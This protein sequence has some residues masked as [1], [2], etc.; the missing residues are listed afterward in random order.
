MSA[1]FELLSGR[2]IIDVAFLPLRCMHEV[3][4]VVVASCN[5]D[6][7]DVCLFDESMVEQGW[8][9]YF[10]LCTSR[11]LLPPHQNSRPIGNK[12][13]LTYRALRPPQK[14]EYWPLVGRIASTPPTWVYNNRN[15]GVGGLLLSRPTKPG[16]YVS[17]AT[18]R[19]GRLMHT[20]VQAPGSIEKVDVQD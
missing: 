13:P 9:P 17:F 15:V 5:H 11:F 14:P 8:L 18:G 12:G 4:V 20:E 7:V 1:L 6:C 16:M 10:Y 2:W 19:P 3:V